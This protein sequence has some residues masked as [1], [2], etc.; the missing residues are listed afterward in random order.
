MMDEAKFAGYKDTLVHAAKQM[1][2]E[3]S[4]AMNYASMAMDYK[5]VCP[6]A[7]SEWYKLSFQVSHLPA[8][9]RSGFFE[10]QLVSIYHVPAE[11]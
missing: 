8:V 9:Q 6:Y 5:T 3:Y 2:E 4:D 7:S 11:T 1:A 10:S